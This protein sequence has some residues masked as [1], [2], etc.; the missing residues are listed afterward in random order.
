M[1][2]DRNQPALLQ[3]IAEILAEL[4]HQASWPV[5]CWLQTT[6][7][8][9]EYRRLIYELQATDELAVLVE[10]VDT[11]DNVADL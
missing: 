10:P 8:E 7:E 6:H 9:S 4:L 11:V 5:S 1:K 3:A 2:S